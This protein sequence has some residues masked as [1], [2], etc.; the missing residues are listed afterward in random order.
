MNRYK[1]LIART[2]NG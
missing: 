1:Q 2:Y